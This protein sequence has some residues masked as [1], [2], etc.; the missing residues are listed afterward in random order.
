MSGRS[1]AEVKLGSKLVVES[2]AKLDAMLIAARS[3]NE[4]MDGIAKQS[5]DH[6]ASIEEVNAAVRQMDEMTQHNAALVEETNA[7][8][9]QTEQQAVELDKIVDVFRLNEAVAATPPSR[10]RRPAS[11]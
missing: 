5:Q 4:L 11:T 1:G 7:S 2:A 10:R 8:I 6:A 3:S 9:E